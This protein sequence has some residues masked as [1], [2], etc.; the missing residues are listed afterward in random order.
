LPGQKKTALAG[1]STDNASIVNGYADLDFLDPINMGIEE[2][3]AYTNFKNDY[4]LS[5]A[6]TT[7]KS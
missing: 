3:E 4:A 5:I 1:A 2:R 6:D 7:N